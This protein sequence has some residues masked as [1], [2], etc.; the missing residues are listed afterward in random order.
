M[1]E[2]DRPAMPEADF[3]AVDYFVNEPGRA[4][5]PPPTLGFYLDSALDQPAMA[6]VTSRVVADVQALLQRTSNPVPKPKSLMFAV[7]RGPM[8]GGGYAKAIGDL[9]AMLRAGS[10]EQWRITFLAGRTDSVASLDWY[11]VPDDPSAAV[12]MSLIVFPPVWP[13]DRVDAVAE[14]LVTLVAS[15]AS[16]LALLSGAVTYDRLLPTPSPYERWYGLNHW[17][18]APQS[19]DYLRGYYWA[20]LLTSGH[21]SRLSTL[22]P[23]G[24]IRIEELPSSAG[25]TVL[26]RS[27]HPIS[28]FDN[29]RLAA[30]KQFL[31]P[32]LFPA[33]YRSYEGYP[34]RIIR[35][36]G[37]A[38]RQ[39]APGTAR[40]LLE[41]GPEQ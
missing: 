34:L 37:T 26:V 23:G 1:N 3:D 20:N 24:D 18:T 25:R 32:A 4:P 13:P 41:P 15:W 12:Q 30:M 5:G 33:E 8:G 7:D 21:L 31:A 16:P 2:R 39:V 29:R 27:T 40:P 38:H 22:D 6:D 19:R 17:R 9:L 35:D 28:Q 14:D 11:A 36:P 10:L